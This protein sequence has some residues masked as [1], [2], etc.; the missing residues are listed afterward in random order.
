MPPPR[1][2]WTQESED[3]DE[4]ACRLQAVGNALSV[5][6]ATAAPVY[7]DPEWI[8]QKLDRARNAL[9]VIQARVDELRIEQAAQ[10]AR[11]EALRAPPEKP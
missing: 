8:A 2:K 6:C 4:A 1:E 5:A 11:V 9:Q 10:Q 3:F 7:D